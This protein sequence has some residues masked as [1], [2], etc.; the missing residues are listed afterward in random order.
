MCL[1]QTACP[2]CMLSSGTE[3]SWSSTPLTEDVP[4][5]LVLVWSQPVL[6]SVFSFSMKKNEQPV[7]AGVNG[8]ITVQL[9]QHIQQHLLVETLDCV[10]W[11]QEDLLLLLHACTSIYSNFYQTHSIR[12]DIREAYH[13]P[14]KCSYC[15]SVCI[16]PS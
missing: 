2:A 7:G 3:F 11:H 12:Y 13:P 4:N 1:S 9:M 8:I 6:A 16:S 14:N 10:V 15:I 5:L